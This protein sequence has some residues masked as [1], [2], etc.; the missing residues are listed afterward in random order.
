MDRNE[1]LFFWKTESF[2][3]LI[4]MFNCNDIQFVWRGHAYNI[5]TEYKPC[6]ANIDSDVTNSEIYRQRARF[7]DT[8]E[9]LILHHT[10]EDGST[11][12]EA[13]ASEDLEDY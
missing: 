9:D 6:V 11:L 2:N 10:F 7:Y 3:D 5:T 13:L 1:K 8:Y 12:L 4:E